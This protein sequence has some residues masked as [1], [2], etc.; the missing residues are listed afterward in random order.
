VTATPPAGIRLRGGAP[1]PPA[2]SFG[3][4]VSVIADGIRIGGGH[5]TYP[6]HW[7]PVCGL[8]DCYR[9]LAP[10]PDHQ[11]AREALRGHWGDE[12]REAAA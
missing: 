4:S 7:V 11:K 2:P 9:P 3:R 12:H 10:Q 5:E 8:G 1:I 6:G